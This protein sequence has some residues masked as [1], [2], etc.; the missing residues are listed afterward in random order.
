MA[1]LKRDGS[2][3]QEVAQVLAEILPEETTQVELLRK[4]YVDY[5]LS[6]VPVLTR[7]QLEELDRLLKKSKRGDESK[8]AIERWLQAQEERLNND[9][10][11]G[12]L[13]TAEEFLFAFERWRN[14]KHRDVAVDLLKRGWLMARNAAPKEATAISQRLEQFG[15]TRLRGQW[16]TIE[17][18]TDLPRDDVELAMREGRVV[19]G[20]TARQVVGTLGQPNRTIRVISA[21]QIQEIWVYGEA[22]SSA[23]TVHVQRGRREKPDAA[24]VTLVS[25][26]L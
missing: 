24:V 2:N 13:A 25:K 3:G 10:L 19:V 14:P 20:M 6:R 18:I 26:I 23:I 15:W 21:R 4:A 22:G 9:Q 8:P 17:Q 7:R 12:I 5:R 16:M 11:D 1:Q